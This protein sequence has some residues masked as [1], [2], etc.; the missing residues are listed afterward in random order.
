MALDR[1][2]GLYH[3]TFH[4]REDGETFFLAKALRGHAID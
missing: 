3:E 1:Q 4:M 2:E